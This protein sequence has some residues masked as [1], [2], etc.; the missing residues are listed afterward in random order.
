VAVVPISRTDGHRHIGE[1]M[2]DEDIFDH[3]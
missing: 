1:T 2:R 3:G